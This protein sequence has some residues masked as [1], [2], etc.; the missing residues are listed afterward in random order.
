M[1]TPNAAFS[2]YQNRLA[3]TVGSI[4]KLDDGV[5]V[6]YYS[7]IPVHTTD[8]DIAE[9]L[10]PD[11]SVR[12]NFDFYS[13]KWG[14]SMVTVNLLNVREEKT[15]TAAGWQGPSDVLGSIRNADATLYLFCG[16]LAA[17][18]STIATL[19][20][21]CVTSFKGKV[22]EAPKYD[23]DYLTMRLVDEFSVSD[24]MLPLN[25]MG[26]TFDG[27]PTENITKKIIFIL[28]RN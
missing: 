7:S 26:D 10:Q 5:N 21:K 6:Y 27:V 8:Q 15:A 19:L 13:K 2:D 14:V 3:S 16:E 9:L 11:W 28:F 12:Q 18:K 22:L 25:V 4:L 24:V 17:D 20:G 23:G 1:L